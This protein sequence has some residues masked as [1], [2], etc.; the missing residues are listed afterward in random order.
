VNLLTKFRALKAGFIIMFLATPIHAENQSKLDQP[1]TLEL[2]EYLGSLVD[3]ND[4]LVGPDSF[5]EKGIS[6]KSAISQNRKSLEKLK[7]NKKEEVDEK[8]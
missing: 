1:A 2:L 8:F 4:E 6:D 7:D 5:I 3:S